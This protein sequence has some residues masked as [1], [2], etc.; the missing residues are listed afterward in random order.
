MA[1]SSKSL[2]DHD[3]DT[4]MPSVVFNM[5]LRAALR[6]ESFSALLHEL[7]PY[8]FLEAREYLR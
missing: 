3:E 4:I 6:A 8:Y 7:L 2:S 5:I 1:V